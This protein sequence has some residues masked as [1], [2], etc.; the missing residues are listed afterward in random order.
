MDV[1]WYGDRRPN[2][3]GAVP[4]SWVF[5]CDLAPIQKGEEM[6]SPMTPSRRLVHV[7][8]G[9][10][11]SLSL[12]RD[13]ERKKAWTSDCPCSD[14]HSPRVTIGILARLTESFS[15][16]GFKLGAKEATMTRSGPVTSSVSGVS[17]RVSLGRCPP[18]LSV[19]L[20]SQKLEKHALAL[21]RMH[22]DISNN[23]SCRREKT[24]T[25]LFTC[26]LSVQLRN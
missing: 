15:G 19:F 10:T 17:P 16:L 1:V 20:R 2:T 25:V 24:R 23:V 18:S 13:H 9:C 6:V 8:R 26:V 5:L 11:V 7:S 3:V 14:A 12:P 22:I 4:R 21:L